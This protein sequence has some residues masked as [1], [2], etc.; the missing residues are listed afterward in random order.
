LFLLVPKLLISAPLQSQSVRQS[1]PIWPI[2]NHWW[3]GVCP[4]FVR[5]SLRSLPMEN[6]HMQVLVLAST[7][8]IISSESVAT[9]LEASL[10]NRSSSWDFIS[11]G[12]S[13]G[14]KHYDAD[15]KWGSDYL[16]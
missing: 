13:D 15:S 5:V 2:L 1:M 11:G 4:T 12:L 9:L 16:P 8:D 7:L 14:T 6:M 3:E 10:D